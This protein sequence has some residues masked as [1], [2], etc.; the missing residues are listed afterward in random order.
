MLEKICIIANFVKIHTIRPGLPGH[1]NEKRIELQLDFIVL[2]F[3]MFKAQMKFI[4]CRRDTYMRW[5][6]RMLCAFFNFVLKFDVFVM[7]TRQY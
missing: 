3:F 4:R 2:L 5:F 6:L 7:T 1:K